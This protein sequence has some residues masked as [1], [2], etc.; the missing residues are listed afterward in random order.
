MGK[1]PRRKT[2]SSLSLPNHESGVRLKCAKMTMEL[3]LLKRKYESLWLQNLH[4]L[5]C[6]NCEDLVLSEWDAK[7]LY[8]VLCKKGCKVKSLNLAENNFGADVLKWVAKALYNN[9]QLK[10]E[11]LNLRNNC[12]SNIDAAITIK[13]A[14]K[15]IKR[16]DLS[17]NDLD[18]T[19]VKVILSA[20][21]E[22]PLQDLQLVECNLSSSAVIP[23][24][25]LIKKAV[26]LEK[27][28]CSKNRLG[29]T[30]CSTL[31]NSVVQ[32]NSSQGP[33][34]EF[35][36]STLEANFDDDEAMETEDWIDIFRKRLEYDID[37]INERGEAVW[38][39][40]KVLAMLMRNASTTIYPIVSQSLKD[41]APPENLWASNVQSTIKSTF[42]KLTQQRANVPI[43]PLTVRFIED[44]KSQDC[45]DCMPDEDC[46]RCKK[47]NEFECG[48]WDETEDVLI[49]VREKDKQRMQSFFSFDVDVYRQC[50]CS[51]SEMPNDYLKVIYIPGKKSGTIMDTL[52]QNPEKEL[53]VLEE[54]FSR[55][56]NKLYE[57][58]SKSV[59]N[60]EKM[61]HQLDLTSDGSKR[62]SDGS[63]PSRI[64]LL[65]LEASRKNSNLNMLEVHIRSDSELPI[66]RFLVMIAEDD[67]ESFEQLKSLREI[68]SANFRSDTFGVLCLKPF[69]LDGTNFL[70]FVLQNLSSYTRSSSKPN[71]SNSGDFSVTSNQGALDFSMVSKQV[72][73]DDIELDDQAPQLRIENRKRDRDVQ[74]E[75]LNLNPVR[76]A[77][78]NGARKPFDIDNNLAMRDKSPTQENPPNPLQSEEHSREQTQEVRGSTSGGATDGDSEKARV[79][80]PDTDSSSEDDLVLNIGGAASD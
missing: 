66:N 15:N 3:E 72:S 65:L 78:F 24:C 29:K 75:I 74:P 76:K 63:K 79:S 1:E 39:L 52:E 53:I 31:F 34:G 4:N 20:L 64:P 17:G 10:L 9:D 40:P 18:E 16:L 5:E 51:F 25:D 33:N 8:K 35:T 43:L 54:I 42:P 22:A 49:L 70:L 26:H 80:S 56:L 14:V 50:R 45:K 69:R 13:Y 21:E 57:H 71:S 77:P 60:L 55:R 27:L 41:K 7:I 68:G 38:E 11:T 37:Q 48:I 23:L 6:I 58:N 44:L 2:R 47:M 73:N 46:E 67:V 12:L 19:G 28:N 62:N 32:F 59:Y 61:I 30:G 36:R